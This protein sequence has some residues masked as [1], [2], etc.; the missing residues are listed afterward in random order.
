MIIGSH[1]SISGG[2]FNA[3]SHAKELGFHAVAIFTRNQRRWTA[4]PLAQA[5]I[6]KFR[7]LREQAE[8]SH[9]VAH[10]SYLA[11]LGSQNEQ[12]RQKSHDALVDEL[13][14]C[15]QLGA[16]YLVLHPGSNPDKS[17][18]TKLIAEGIIAALD[19]ANP[20]KV[21]LLLETTAGQGNCIGHRFEE[22]GKIIKLVEAKTSHQLGVCLDTCHI[23]A[24]G[25]DLRTPETYAETFAEFDANV[26]LERLCAIHC[27][28][29]LKP[30]GSRVDRHAHIAQGE[31]GKAGFELLV[32]DPALFELP[33][34]LETPKDTDQ[35]GA[36]MDIVN[37]QLLASLVK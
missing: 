32:N 23:F 3:I 26:G 37:S 20:Q 22:I 35:T 16:D 5:D 12:T 7:Q 29:S 11:N 18:G 8:I 33:F 36:D 28:D 34:I 6:D 25:Y 24:A 15:D 1:L 30:L 17:A 27:N 9:V 21:R 13:T 31:I 2:V 14:R 19:Q 4:K 10:A